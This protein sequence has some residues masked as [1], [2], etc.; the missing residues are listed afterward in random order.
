M[1]GAALFALPFVSWSSLSEKWEN[2]IIKCVEKY[3]FDGKD[4]AGICGKIRWRIEVELTFSVTEFFSALCG[5]SAEYRHDVC[6][7]SS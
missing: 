3:L 2:L 5:T 4:N 7:V 6:R 1:S